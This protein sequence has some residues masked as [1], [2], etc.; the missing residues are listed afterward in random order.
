MDVKII[1]G[2]NGE[3]NFDDEGKPRIKDNQVAGDACDHW[4]RY[5]DDILMLKELGVTHYRFSLNGVRLN[6]SKIS[7]MKMR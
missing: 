6:L 4:N 1:I 5:N 3:N 7:L 2:I